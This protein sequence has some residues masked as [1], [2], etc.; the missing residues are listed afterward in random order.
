MGIFVGLSIAVAS[1]IIVFV[2]PGQP[3]GLCSADV[4]VPEAT[5]PATAGHWFCSEIVVPQRPSG[6]CGNSGLVNGTPVVTDF[7][8]YVFSLHLFARCISVNNLG[9]NASVVRPSGSVFNVT[10]WTG[11]GYWAEWHNWTSPQN[12][13]GFQW[14]PNLTPTGVGNVSLLIAPR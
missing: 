4:W 10:F 13:T 8:G 6:T 12:D 5:T 1:I 7:R 14:Q 9:L 3:Q 11:A 2:Y